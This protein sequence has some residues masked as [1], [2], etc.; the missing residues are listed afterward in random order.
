[1]P[2]RSALLQWHRLA[3]GG[4]A[5]SADMQKVCFTYPRRL[6]LNY[7]EQERHKLETY[8]CGLACRCD[9]VIVYEQ[10]MPQLPQAGATQAGGIQVRVGLQM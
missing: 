1:M 3:D 8:R 9:N 7:L 10:T 6:S 2:I 5:V 4:G